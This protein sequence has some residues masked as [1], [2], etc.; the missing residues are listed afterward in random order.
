MPLPKRRTSRAKRDRR[1]AHDALTPP[2]TAVCAN[3]GAR[4]Q[5][6]RVCRACGHYKGRAV[7]AVDED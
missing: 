3:C 6:H 7:I 2:A 4:L 5:P 1:R